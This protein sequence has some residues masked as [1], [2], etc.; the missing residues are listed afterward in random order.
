MIVRFDFKNRRGERVEARKL[1]V[2]S[3]RWSW[4]ES[5]N[6]EQGHVLWVGGAVA[7]FERKSRLL[8]ACA[9]LEGQSKREIG[10]RRAFDGGLKSAENRRWL[11]PSGGVTAST[12]T[13]AVKRH[14]GAHTPVIECKTIIA[15]QELA[16]AA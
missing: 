6:E 5:H 3:A 13:F 8:I 9:F 1:A 10:R 4:Y 15:N 16:Y 12:G 14:A 2:T 11:Q 7:D